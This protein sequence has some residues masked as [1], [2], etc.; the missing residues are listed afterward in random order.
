MKTRGEIRMDTGA[1]LA[2]RRKRLWRT[3]ILAVALHGAVLFCVRCG[4]V[5][6][7][8]PPAA[9]SQGVAID[10]ASAPERKS[11]SSPAGSLPVAAPDSRRKTEP[12]APVPESAAS[13]KPEKPLPRKPEK[14]RRN[15]AATSA[16]NGPTM[17]E[18][19]QTVSSARGDA[20][21]SIGASSPE[22]LS[23]QANPKPIY[24]ELARRRGQEGVVRLLADV[25]EKGGVTKLTVVQSSGFALLDAA[26]VKAVRAWRF[27]PGSRNGLPGAGSLVIPVEFRLH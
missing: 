3:T 17:A 15:A 11:P 26:A 14:Q 10:L 12:A 7:T 25:D 22:P 16:G 2:S 6:D 9:H 20:D 8:P 5:P 18:A 21:G 13:R 4:A 24:P 19:G 27:K 1:G 23:F